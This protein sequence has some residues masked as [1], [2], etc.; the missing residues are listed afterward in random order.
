MAV[1]VD[2]SALFAL[3]DADDDNHAAAV[4]AWRSAVETGQPMLATNYVL[5][6]ATALVQNRLGFAAVR[7]LHQDILPLVDIH[8]ITAPVHAAAVEYMLRSSWRKLSLVDCSSFEVMKL[9]SVTVVFC[10]DRHFSEAGFD[11]IPSA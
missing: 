1:F 4:A 8:W 9:L 10:F 11:A 2:T 5:V 6:E 7:A 3:L